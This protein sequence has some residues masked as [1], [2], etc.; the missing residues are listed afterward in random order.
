MKSGQIKCTRIHTLIPEYRGGGDF[1][2]QKHRLGC[3]FLKMA[4]FGP[5]QGKRGM[6]I[7]GA[8]LAI[9]AMHIFCAAQVRRGIPAPLLSV[10]G[11]WFRLV[12][13]ARA[14]RE[15]QVGR[16]DLARK[17]GINVVISAHLLCPRFIS[18]LSQTPQFFAVSDC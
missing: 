4:G 9:G 8:T 15:I 18:E 11:K 14:D 6:P 7:G 17:R 13:N 16:G 2:A 3:A 12:P 1:R 10:G 5:A